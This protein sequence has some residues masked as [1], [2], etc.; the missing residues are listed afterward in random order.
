MYVVMCVVMALC[1]VR[2]NEAKIL[3]L[4]KDLLRHRAFRRG[5]DEVKEDEAFACRLDVVA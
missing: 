4:V 3:D 1:K 2:K 5:S